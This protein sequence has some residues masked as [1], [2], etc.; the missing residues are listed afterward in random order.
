M[1]YEQQFIAARKAYHAKI[2]DMAP[3]RVLVTFIDEEKPKMLAQKLDQTNGKPFTE[4]NTAHNFFEAYRITYIKKLDT[5][6]AKEAEAKK[7]KPTVATYATALEKISDAFGE[8]CEKKRQAEMAKAQAPPPKA[9]AV[10][11]KQTVG[12]QAAD[13]AAKMMLKKI[14]DEF[15]KRRQKHLDVAIVV[16]RFCIDHRKTL[17]TL[18]ETLQKEVHTAMNYSKAGQVREAAGLKIAAAG[19]LTRIKA[20]AAEA[21]KNY[22][23]S[24][25]PFFPE[26][27]MTGETVAKSMH[28]DVPDRF[29]KDLNNIAKTH[30]KIF[31][32]ATAHTASAKRIFEECEELA[33]DAESLVKQINDIADGQDF[34]RLFLESATKMGAR[35]KTIVDKG[36]HN[37]E[38]LKTS[39]IPA[40]TKNVK[41]VTDKAPAP[42]VEGAQGYVNTMT[43]F[44]KT[45]MHECAQSEATCRKLLAAEKQKIPRDLLA[46]E[47]GRVVLAAEQL[48]G[49][50]VTLNAQNAHLAEPLLARAEPLVE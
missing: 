46:G 34:G 9:G 7:I 2:K 20:L 21:K 47:V 31:T 22:Q 32:T 5:Q 10:E 30:A 26:R 23:D 16:E 45:T 11:A 39:I 12:N 8:D 38:K 29:E 43:P 35:L 49:G 3:S 48:L 17:G 41:I 27:N 36:V 18:H 50:L 37:A 33:G 44:L 42:Q 14:S 40:L 15:R 1:G 19:Q 24:L 4:M 6:I 25:N 28:L 13:V